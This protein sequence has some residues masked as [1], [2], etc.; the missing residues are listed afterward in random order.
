M[1]G[2]FLHRRWSSKLLIPT[3]ILL[4]LTTSAP[5]SATQGMFQGRVVEGNKREAGKYI[6]VEGRGGFMRRVDIRRCRIHFDTSIPASQRVRSAAESLR[7]S[8]E[9]RVTADQKANGEWLA[10]DITILKLPEIDHV[11]LLI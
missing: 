3:A 8:A 1:P 4:F 9:V 10:A 2:R 6:Y 5:L 7:E 11:R